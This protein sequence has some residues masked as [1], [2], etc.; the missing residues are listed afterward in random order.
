MP[1]RLN[2]ASLYT[3]R[4]LSFDDIGI[5]VTFLMFIVTILI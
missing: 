2:V 1:W 5:E 4:L 3:F